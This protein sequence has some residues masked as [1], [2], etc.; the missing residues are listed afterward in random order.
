MR[1]MA[2]VGLPSADGTPP[3][4]AQVP[5]AMVAAAPRARPRPAL[6]GPGCGPPTPPGGRGPRGR[7]TPAG[8]SGDPLVR[9]RA[10]E[11]DHVGSSELPFPRIREGPHELRPGLN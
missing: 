10:F 1:L 8:P 2:P 6:V 7:K 4:V 3:H 5:M 9:H 11:H